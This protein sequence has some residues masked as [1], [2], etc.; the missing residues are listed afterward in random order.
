[1]V[2]IDVAV[3]LLKLEELVE[4]VEAVWFVLQISLAVMKGIPLYT[5]R[6]V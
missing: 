4:L 3:E 5:R 6:A 1:V 2:L